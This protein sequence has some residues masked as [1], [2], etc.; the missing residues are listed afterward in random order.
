[1]TV[2]LAQTN[3]KTV[4]Q[5]YNQRYLKC[6]RSE[7]GLE[8]SERHGRANSTDHSLLAAR[9]D[10]AHYCTLLQ[11][12]DNDDEVDTAMLASDL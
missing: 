6:L 9:E 11:N 2:T 12:R 3:V 7:G 10:R 5:L 1:M 8:A 4:R